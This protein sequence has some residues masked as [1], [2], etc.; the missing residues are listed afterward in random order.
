M[1]PA[2]IYRSETKNVEEILLKAL[3]LGGPSVAE[4]NKKE[5]NLSSGDTVL[6]MSDGFPELFDKQKEILGY[7]K[8]KEIFGKVASL[9]GN[10]IISSLCKSAEDWHSGTRQEDDITFVVIK[11]KS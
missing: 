8:A 3:P 7:D 10:Q 1:P 2:L 11:V 4:Y 6:L 5:I 9:P